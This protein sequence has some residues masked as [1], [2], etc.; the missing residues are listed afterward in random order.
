MPPHP[1]PLFR[2]RG[3]F[4]VLLLTH[5]LLQVPHFF[6]GASLYLARCPLAAGAGAGDRGATRGQQ[7][8]VTRCRAEQRG[9]PEGRRT[10]PTVTA[11]GS[12]PGDAVAR[13]AGVACVLIGNDR[14]GGRMGGVMEGTRGGR[15]RPLLLPRS[16]GNLWRR[17]KKGET[18]KMSCSVTISQLI[19]S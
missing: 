6:F 16:C 12:L 19:S 2:L 11:S 7:R 4:Q 9:N 8:S 15:D 1:H 5:T 17:K 13:S 14:D 10:S 18:E 3:P